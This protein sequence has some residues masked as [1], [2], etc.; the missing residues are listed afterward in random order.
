[1]GGRLILRTIWVVGRICRRCS[2]PV[3]AGT[4]MV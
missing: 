2:P 4:L 3:V 1:M